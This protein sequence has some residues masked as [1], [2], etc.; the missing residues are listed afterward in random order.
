MVSHQWLRPRL[1]SNESHPDPIDNEKA[2]VING[3]TKWRRTWIN[4]KQGFIPEIFYWI[5]FCCINQHD[6][7]SAIPLLSLW[8]ACCER[9][10][11]I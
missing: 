11:R 5:H 2:K 8:V 3:F 4:K 10:L 6:L 9:F 7:T 1:N